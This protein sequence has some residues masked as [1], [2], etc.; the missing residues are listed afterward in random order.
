M[1]EGGKPPSR[2]T[3]EQSERAQDCEAPEGRKPLWEISDR[4]ELSSDKMKIAIVSR[5]NTACGVSLHAELVGREWVKERH[6]LTVFAPNN[7][8]PVGGDEEYVIR[9]FSDE[10]N[11]TKTFFHPEPFLDTDY[12]ILVVERV[13]WV[14]LEPLKRCFPEIK[15]KAKTV[16]VVHERKPPTNP[17]FY[18][19]DWDALVCFDDRYKE[20]WQ[21]RFD[22]AKIHIIPYPTG[23]LCKGDKQKAREELGLP[24]DRRIVFSYGWAPELHIYPI[25]P[26]LRRLNEIC[27][28]VYLVLA[29]PKYIA[30]D[31]QPLK[32]PGFIELRYE[33]ASMERIYTYL[34]ASDAYLIHKQVE[35]VRQGEAVVPSAI[36]MCLGVSTP[37][38]TSATEFVWFLDKEVMKYSTRDE[39]CKLLIK[40]FEGDRIVNET[41][42]RAKEY[43]IGHSP[44]KIASGF[45]KLFNRLL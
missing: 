15:K 21:G 30:A 31:I 9:C 44:K 18:Q 25:L 17:L 3:A 37:I 28:F 12:E 45:L 32:D 6:S 20:L 5:W 35:E 29:D 34:H 7:I 26:A 38:I 23:H 4:R 16:Y 14:P 42:K 33:L 2:V 27:P 19:F 11:H 22:E 13:E 36:L 8:R 10:G 39:L 40:V 41:L 24:S 1:F 43:A